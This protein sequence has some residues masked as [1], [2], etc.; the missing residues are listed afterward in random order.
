[1]TLPAHF[2]PIALTLL[3]VE[4]ALGVFVLKPMVI[5]RPFLGERTRF[6]HETCGTCH[7]VNQATLEAQWS[8]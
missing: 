3:L 1:M 7:V 5:S 2:W 6:Y 8:K 4:L